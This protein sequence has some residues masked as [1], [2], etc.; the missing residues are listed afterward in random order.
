MFLPEGLSMITAYDRNDLSSD[1]IKTYLDQ[2]SMATAPF[3]PAKNPVN[4][5]PDFLGI[6]TGLE[7]NHVSRYLYL[8]C[9]CFKLFYPPEPRIEH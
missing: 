1:R 8:N 7:Y 5:D 4:S 9:N 6:K 2:F 3:K